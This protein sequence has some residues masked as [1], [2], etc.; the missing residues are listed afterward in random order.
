MYVGL[1]DVAEFVVVDVPPASM[2]R[3]KWMDADLQETIDERA[4][5]CKLSRPSV[6]SLHERLGRGR[7]T[8]G[9]AM[10]RR[11]L[12]NLVH[13]DED[14]TALTDH[15]HTDESQPA[16]CHQALS[17]RLFLVIEELHSLVPRFTSASG[18]VICRFVAFVLLSCLYLW[19]AVNLR[20][21]FNTMQFAVCVWF[22]Y[23]LNK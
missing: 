6:G 3:S 19:V 13:P 8:N 7:V 9:R 20:C 11:C 14:L 22:G 23:G 17:R 16:H 5:T 2:H 4:F 15:H 18:H 10:P 12:V 21:I 1:D